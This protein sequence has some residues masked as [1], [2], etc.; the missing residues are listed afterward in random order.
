MERERKRRADEEAREQEEKKRR[1]EELERQQM[2]A[3]RVKPA[4]G[5]IKI[6]PNTSGCLHLS[7]A[8]ISASPD[9]AN[10]IKV[11][12]R[13][14]GQ[15]PLWHIPRVLRELKMTGGSFH[16]AQTQ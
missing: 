13:D 8:G 2:E 14:G 16:I 10:K 5:A 3:R 15:P 7:Q 11:E 6:L 1:Q 12:Y 9:V 4:A